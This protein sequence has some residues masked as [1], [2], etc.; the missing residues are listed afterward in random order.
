MLQQLAL[1]TEFSGSTN[2]IEL[3][4]LVM[5]IDESNLQGNVTVADISELATEFNLAIDQLDIDR[6][7][8]PAPT[9]PRD[10]DTDSTST[11]IPEELLTNLKLQGQLQ[12]SS[13]SVAGMDFTQM[14]LTLN[15]ANGQ[16]DLAPLSTNL[17]Q[18]SFEGNIHV[19]VADSVPVASVEANLRQIELDPLLQ[20]LVDATYLSG[21]GNIQL[22]LTSSGADTDAMRADPCTYVAAGHAR[23]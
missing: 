8:P 10:G 2:S 12:V 16:L 5:I 1:N 14:S 17:Y 6:Y 22:A 18:G 13:L 7:L 23:I 3:S 21:K 9:Q 4:N 20:D 19:S 11:E 15:A